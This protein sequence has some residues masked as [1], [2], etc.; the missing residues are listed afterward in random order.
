MV[1]THIIQDA[2]IRH[3]RP[4]SSDAEESASLS[5]H[6]PSG[7]APGS[8]LTF[9]TG[10]D[11]TLAKLR[12]PTPKLHSPGLGWEQQPQGGNLGDILSSAHSFNSASCKEASVFHRTKG[13]SCTGWRAVHSLMVAGTPQAMFSQ[14]SLQS[15]P[16]TRWY[17]QMQKCPSCK[18]LACG[19]ADKRA[20]FYTTCSLGPHLFWSP[21]F[22]TDS[23]S[24]GPSYERMRCASLGLSPV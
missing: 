12:H 2:L 8:V 4:L 22:V 21:L 23:S 10:K 5:L 3:P 6:Q 1:S 20:H 17:G 9:K 24:P 11:Q 16:I 15:S 14:R 19:Q 7:K 18:A 13:K